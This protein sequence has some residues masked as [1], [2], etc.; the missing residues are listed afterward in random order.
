MRSEVQV[1]TQDTCI[2]FFLV[3]FLGK[4]DHNVLIFSF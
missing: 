2:S 3:S 1:L 4:N